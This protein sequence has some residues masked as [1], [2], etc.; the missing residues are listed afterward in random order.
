MLTSEHGNYMSLSF[1]LTRQANTNRG[2]QAMPSGV[3]L[4]SIRFQRIN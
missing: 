2:L 1:E 4:L 3:I